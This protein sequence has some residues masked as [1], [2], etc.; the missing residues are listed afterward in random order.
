MICQQLFPIGPGGT[1]EAYPAPF[2]TWK[3]W[4][5]SNANTCPSGSEATSSCGPS[6]LSVAGKPTTADQPPPRARVKTPLVVVATMRWKSSRSLRTEGS[7]GGASIVHWL[8][9]GAQRKLEN[10]PWDG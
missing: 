3:K 8:A 5:M 2:G 9:N 7:A 1:S 6:P 4:K 10:T